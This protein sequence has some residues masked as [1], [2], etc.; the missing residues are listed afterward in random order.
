[1]TKHSVRKIISD[2]MW[3]KLGAAVAVRQA[4]AGGRPSE[5]KRSGVS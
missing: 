2:A 5:A 4:F 3:K 1:M